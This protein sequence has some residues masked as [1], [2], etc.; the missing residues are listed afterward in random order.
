MASRCAITG[1]WYLFSPPITTGPDAQVVTF[2]VHCSLLFLL[3]H[4]AANA[5]SSH[6]IG[7]P[8]ERGEQIHHQRTRGLDI[9]YI[10]VVLRGIFC[11]LLWEAYENLSA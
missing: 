9:R 6:K 1:A 4:A 5:C 10:L 3:Q 8:S 2:R 11:I 7:R